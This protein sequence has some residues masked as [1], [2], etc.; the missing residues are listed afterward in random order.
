MEPLLVVV[1]LTQYVEHLGAE[2]GGCAGSAF[3]PL[4]DIVLC[5]LCVCGM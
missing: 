5:L 1:D 2:S 3:G 4:L